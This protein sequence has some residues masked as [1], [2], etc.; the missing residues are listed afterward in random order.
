MIINELCVSDNSLWN[1][2]GRDLFL[3]LRNFSKNV[4]EFVIECAVH[5]ESE[6]KFL[7]DIGFSAVTKWYSLAN[8]I[9]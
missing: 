9:L 6:Q 4:E 5:D 1:T 3:S 8:E 2:V 7:N